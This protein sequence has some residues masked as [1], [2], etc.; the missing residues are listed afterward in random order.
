MCT[1]FS[2]IAAVRTCPKCFRIGS[3]AAFLHRFVASLPQ[4][5]PTIA[6]FAAA[7]SVVMMAS[8]NHVASLFCKFPWLILQPNRYKMA[9]GSPKPRVDPPS[10]FQ[11]EG[12]RNKRALPLTNRNRGAADCTPALDSP[13]HSFVSLLSLAP[14]HALCF[15]FSPL[16]LFCF[17]PLR[18]FCFSRALAPT[19]AYGNIT[20]PVPFSEGPPSGRAL[21]WPSF[22]PGRRK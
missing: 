8:K 2:E 15:R 20:E 11:P 14:T 19:P 5:R 17:S 10:G 6:H 3:P 9:A 21:G 7:S 12:P 18:L 22:R 16:R 4:K 13:T 1:R